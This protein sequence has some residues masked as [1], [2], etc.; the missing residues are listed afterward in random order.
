MIDPNIP[1]EELSLKSIKLIKEALLNKVKLHNSEKEVAINFG[2]CS[3]AGDLAI[4]GDLS[5]SQFKAFIECKE[6]LASKKRKFWRA[7]GRLTKSNL[8]FLWRPMDYKPRVKWL[9]KLIRD[10]K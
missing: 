7:N 8:Q 9:N 1:K 6:D 10:F 4:N 5:S 3:I 2:L